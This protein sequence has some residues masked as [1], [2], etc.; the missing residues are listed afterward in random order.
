MCMSI[1]GERV[2]KL[3]RSWWRTKKW[4]SRFLS[5]TRLKMRVGKVFCVCSQGIER[6]CESR[7]SRILNTI[8]QEK[9]KSVSDNL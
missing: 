6:V 9:L 7:A 3:L 2:K 1:L 4:P 8:K 5:S